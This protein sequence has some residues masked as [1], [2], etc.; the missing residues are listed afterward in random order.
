MRSIEYRRDGGCA[1]AKG[2]RIGS[3]QSE[4][5]KPYIGSSPLR[6]P[7][8]KEGANAVAPECK[9]GTL[10][11]VDITASA[12]LVAVRANDSAV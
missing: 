9:H 4:L 8:L 2:H 6:L 1:R 10:V 7:Y 12:S 5:L 3:S 11:L